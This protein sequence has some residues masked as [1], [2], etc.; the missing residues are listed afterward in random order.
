MKV[1]MIGSTGH[2]K[3]VL[4]GLEEYK[5]AELVGIAPGSAGES[6]DDLY[7]R[8]G[9]SG[10]NPKLFENYMEMLDIL[11]PDVVAVACHFHNHAS[12]TVQAMSRGIHVFVEKPVATTLEDLD[13][14]KEAYR[15]SGVQLAT[16]FGIRYKPAFLTA[17]KLISEGKIGTVRLMNAQKS[18][19][20]NERSELFHN[21]DTYGGTIPWV[22]SHAIDWMYWLSGEQFCSV[23]ATHSTKANR[24]HKDLEATALCHFTFGNEVYGSASID[25]LRPQQAPTHADDRIRVVGTNGVLEVK[26]EKVFLINDEFEGIQEMPLLPPQEILADFLRQLDGTGTCIISA[27]DS[28]MV[29]EA[30]LKA[31]Q[32]ADEGRIVYF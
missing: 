16:M 31:R 9:R 21:R 18:Y 24:D 2:T 28:F 22:G 3:Y 13:L 14:V 6:M 8:A 20:L 29:T 5:E 7:K 17:K 32:S 26:E 25:Y 19:R 15:C 10:F 30:C 23:Y 4:N 11:K 27:E 12:V 1:C